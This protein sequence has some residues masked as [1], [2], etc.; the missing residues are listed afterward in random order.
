MSYRRLNRFCKKQP[1]G[2][3]PP[4]LLFNPHTLPA[5]LAVDECI[6]PDGHLDSWY[7]IGSIDPG[8]KNSGIRIEKRWLKSR[9]V[10]MVLYAIMNSTIND[11]QKSTDITTVNYHV[12]NVLLMDRFLEYFCQCHYIVIECQMTINYDLVRF[13]Q[14][15]ITYLIIKCKDKGNRPLIIELDSHYKT[16]LLGASLKLTKDQRKAWCTQKAISM[17]EQRGDDT[18][19]KFLSFLRKKDDCGDAACQIEVWWIILQGLYEPPKP[20]HDPT[21]LGK[22]IHQPP[23]AQSMKNE[24]TQLVVDEHSSTQLVIDEDLSTQ[25]VIDEPSLDNID[26][27]K[28][29]NL[30]Q[31]HITTL[32]LVD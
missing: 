6:G 4:Y 22:L 10:E 16:R 8:P 20:S 25:L 13:S 7:A 21:I 29:I 23:L 5:P 12:N 19:L 31:S 32:L 27:N 26:Q 3:K 30:S 11:D 24:K 2:I 17:F 28:H 18:S 14:H 15:L 9:H 1:T